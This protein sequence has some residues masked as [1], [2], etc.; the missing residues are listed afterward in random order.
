MLPEQR[1]SDV[2]SYLPFQAPGGVASGVEPK[3]LCTAAQEPNPAPVSNS[4]EQ[5]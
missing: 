3:L 2:E 1:M 4:Y 5:V